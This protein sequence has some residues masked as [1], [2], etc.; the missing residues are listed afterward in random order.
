MEVEGGAG[1]WVL[2][3]VAAMREGEW[4]QVIAMARIWSC[5]G[6][7]LL[8]LFDLRGGRVLLLF[9]L[10]PLPH[11]MAGSGG[12]LR[13]AGGNFC[14]GRAGMSFRLRVCTVLYRGSSSILELMCCRL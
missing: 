10:L 2:W 6:S 14:R 4:D 11:K 9:I 1:L 3:D 7:T 13:V 12:R 8:L 5:L